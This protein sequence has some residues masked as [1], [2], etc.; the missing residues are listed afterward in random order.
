MKGAS[1]DLCIYCK[2]IGESREHVA[3]SSLGGNCVIRCV[4]KRCNSALSSVD[5]ALAENS[6]VALS[7]VSVT[8][9]T[10]FA[11]HLGSV[12]SLRDS[13]GHDLG[14][15]VGNHMAV[16]VCPQ[17][18]LQGEQIRFHCADRNR[19]AKFIEYIDK[20]IKTNRLASIFQRIAPE[21]TDPRLMMHRSNDAVLDAASPE[22]AIRLISVLEKNWSAIKE[23][24]TNA[25]NMEE[26]R[27]PSP[28]VLIKMEMLPNE[29]YRGIAKLAFETTALLLGADSVLSE[30]FDP[31]RAYI[32]GDVRLPLID[33]NAPDQLAVDSRFVGRVTSGL[34]FPFT[35][36]HGVVLVHEPTYGLAAMV[37][38]Y[39]IHHYKV[40][41]SPPLEKHGWLRHYEFMYTKDG[42]GELSDLE[43]ARR[44]LQLF[45]S[46]LSIDSN[47]AIEMLDLLNGEHK[48]TVCAKTRK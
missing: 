6:P 29:E 25:E 27:Q 26:I 19:L 18:F 12:A 17:L 13:S 39:G 10:A 7:K 44:A 8:P 4:C 5:Q 33:E 36:H 23:K 1:T 20:Q 3:P 35:E 22:E 42:H 48:H 2:Q 43:F 24:L 9:T 37:I 45:P 21:N 28:S 32:M 40:S 31:I 41:L 14:V 30:S 47:K 15:R 34:P 11:T 16:E 38:L 46:A